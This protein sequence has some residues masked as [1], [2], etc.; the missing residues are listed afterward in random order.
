M[1][2][3]NTAKGPRQKKA[4]PSPVRENAR[5]SAAT[6]IDLLFEQLGGPDQARLVQL[7]RHWEMVM[8]E[9]LSALGRPLGRKDRTL[10]VGAQDAM[11]LQ[12]LSL[13]GPEMLER[14]NAFMDKPFFTRVKVSLMQERPDLARKREQPEYRPEAPAPAPVLGAHLGRMKPDSPVARCYE[15]WARQAPGRGK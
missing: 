2:A 6:A 1:N 12:E 4:G 10:L 3:K 9:N 8:G 15:A 11:A 14:A 5:L 13:Q 7:W